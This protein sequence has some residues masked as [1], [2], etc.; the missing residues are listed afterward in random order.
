MK[1]FVDDT[2]YEAEYSDIAIEYIVKLP[3]GHD[4]SDENKES[5]RLYNPKDGYYYLQE[6]AGEAPWEQGEIIKYALT[7][8]SNIIVEHEDKEKIT[9]IIFN[10]A[11]LNA[12]GTKFIAIHK[13]KEDNTL[14]LMDKQGFLDSVAAASYMK[15]EKEHTK[16]RTGE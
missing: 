7:I 4:H 8:G 12:K 3:K 9:D 2:I 11:V 14:T 10:I 6:L 16:T 15:T 1:I 5:I 13:N